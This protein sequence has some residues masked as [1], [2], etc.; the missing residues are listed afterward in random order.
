MRS[1]SLTCGACR[2]SLDRQETYFGAQA[3]GNIINA[4]SRVDSRDA[5][6]FTT[7]AAACLRTRP[8]DF[9]SQGISSIL[10]AYAKRPLQQ[11]PDG[12]VAPGLV[13]HL[14]EAILSIHPRDWSAQSVGITVN[15]L[16]RLKWGIEEGDRVLASEVYRHMA[17]CGYELSTSVLDVQ[18]VSN[19]A[20]AFCKPVVRQCVGDCGELNALMQRLVRA[21]LDLPPEGFTPQGVA[22]V[23]RALLGRQEGDTPEGALADYRAGGGS[24]VLAQRLCMVAQGLPPE[25]YSLQA[26]AVLCSTFVGGIVPLGGEARGLF[27]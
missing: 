1:M 23:A 19:I 18:A 5:S 8:G 3:I 20:N 9:D 16:A 10:N 6:I 7:M 24:D 26:V 2:Q 11:Q 13:S 25:D 22:L 21:G 12:Q 4:F 14:S 17:T 15:A 27:R